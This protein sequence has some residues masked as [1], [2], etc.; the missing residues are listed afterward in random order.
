M[1]EAGAPGGGFHVSGEEFAEMVDLAWQELPAVFR[2]RLDN[3]LVSPATAEQEQEFKNLFGLYQG[4]PEPNNL[5]RHHD[6][7]TLWQ[8][9]MERFCSTR[10][11]LEAQVRTTLFHEVGHHFG[12]TEDE[13]RRATYPEGQADLA[14]WAAEAEGDRPRDPAAALLVLLLLVPVMGLYRA[15]RDQV[16]PF[17]EL[18]IASL[19]AAGA[20]AVLFALTGPIA[21]LTLFLPGF[22][23]PAGLVVALYLGWQ[24]RGRRN[25]LRSAAGPGERSH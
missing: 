22:S 1:S 17:D 11:E 18:L 24:H 13:V 10:E 14:W 7:I 15:W 9:T 5:G 23:I 19:L 25:T 4:V 2:N 20:T 8:S 21:L 6:R 12:L 16:W 3:V